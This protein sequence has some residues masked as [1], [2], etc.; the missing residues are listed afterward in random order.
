MTV[1]VE[2]C[3]FFKVRGGVLPN[4]GIFILVIHLQWFADEPTL[5]HH[6]LLSIQQLDNFLFV[7]CP[8]DIGCPTE[9]PLINIE[10][11]KSYFYATVPRLAD[12]FK[13]LNITG[14]RRK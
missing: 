10:A 13:F 4:A 2:F 11:R 9:V 12:V 5:R 3:H 8:V 6:I 14:Y 1:L 7:C